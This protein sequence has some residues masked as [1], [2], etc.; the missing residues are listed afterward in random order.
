MEVLEFTGWAHATLTVTGGALVRVRLA[1]A[2]ATHFYVQ[3]GTNA[4]APLE[5]HA[6]DV[7]HSGRVAAIV[8][9][10]P[11]AHRLVLRLRAKVR[12]EFACSAR[13]L[14]DAA[15]R[16]HQPLQLHAPTHAPDVVDGVPAGA[17]LAVPATTTGDAW[18]ARVVCVATIASGDGADGGAPLD[19]D[20][21]AVVHATPP[22]AMP[23]GALLMLPCRLRAPRPAALAAQC[24]AA[25][26]RSGDGDAVVPVTVHVTGLA[27]DAGAGGV[28]AEAGRGGGAAG[29]GR[30]RG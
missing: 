17:L 10:P 11:G 25:R 24:A 22:L 6:G 2:G 14:V 27:C 13:A 5:P 26:S 21:G 8:G 15:G 23:P 30:R 28:W 29:A 4:S 12:T 19:G 20:A 3:R 1:C 16:G 18:L 7:Y 9:L